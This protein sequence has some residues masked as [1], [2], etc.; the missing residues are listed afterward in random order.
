MILKAESVLPRAAIHI[1]AA[2]RRSTRVLASVAELTFRRLTDVQAPVY[3]FYHG[4]SVTYMKYSKR[5]KN[6]M[7]DFFTRIRRLTAYL[8]ASLFHTWTISL[9]FWDWHSFDRARKPIHTATENKIFCAGP[10]NFLS[11]AWPFSAIRFA[12]DGQ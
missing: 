9:G 10:A 2:Q 12:I 8:L 1:E 6:G 7:H 3:D 5:R 11:F 4:I